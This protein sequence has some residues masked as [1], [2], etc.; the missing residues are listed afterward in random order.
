MSTST[1]DLFLDRYKHLEELCRDAF[2]L[3]AGESA[4][5]ELKRR[6]Q[7]RSYAEDIDYCREVRNFLQH[8]P[9][10]G[11]QYPVEPSEQMVAFIDDLI[12]RI[13][14]RK[15][16]IQ[17]AVK[18]QEIHT[19]AKS[20]PLAKCLETMGAGAFSHLPVIEDG[21]VVGIVDLH[22]V[23]KA[24]NGA[25]GDKPRGLTVSDMFDCVRIQER[26]G[27]YEHPGLKGEVYDFFSINAFVDE[28]EGEFERWFK[29]G[30]RLG[31]ALLTQN[32]KQ[33]EKLLGLVTAWDI[34]GNKDS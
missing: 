29:Q 19:C 17:I 27:V 15:R 5:I 8:N 28:L 21:R 22:T 2:G 6:K 34:L 20:D 25:G 3:D 12:E 9:K 14:Q 18:G 11:G 24:V 32:G 7:F 1:A 4:L 26:D 33:H 23:L 16:C 31:V 10:L 13:Q 30:R